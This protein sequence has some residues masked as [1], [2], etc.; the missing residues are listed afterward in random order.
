MPN[1]AV[2]TLSIQGFVSTPAEKVDALMAHAQASDK[3]QTALYGKNVTSL[4]WLFEQ[5]SH[6]IGA[7]CQNIQQGYLDYFS[8]HFDTVDVEV[9][10]D[11]TQAAPENRITLKMY[12]SFTQDNKPYTVG[13]LLY[14]L[15][16]R[17]AETIRIKE[18]GITSN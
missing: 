14:G 16:G 8:R 13:N 18:N 10:P 12:I 1:N 9:I 17:Y 2:A 6:D 4:A 7:L 15:N 11:P 5:Y 3:S